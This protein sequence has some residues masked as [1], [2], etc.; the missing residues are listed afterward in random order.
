MTPSAM[1]V[2]LLLGEVHYLIASSCL[3]SSDGWLSAAQIH[4]R[5][6]V[7]SINLHHALAELLF[8]GAVTITDGCISLSETLPAEVHAYVDS[9]PDA[10]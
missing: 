9:V 6:C 5:T 4:R 10:S 3:A 2:A 8:V 1:N 7:G